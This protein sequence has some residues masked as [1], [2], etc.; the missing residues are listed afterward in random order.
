MKKET[1]KDHAEKGFMKGNFP[2]FDLYED[3]VTIGD[4]CYLDTHQYSGISNRSQT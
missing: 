1:K 3:T 4:Y 2:R